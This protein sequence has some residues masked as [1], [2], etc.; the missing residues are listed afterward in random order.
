MRRTNGGLDREHGDFDCA[1][2]S[3]S[4]HRRK[5]KK[6]MLAHQ[7]N[8][9]RQYSGAPLRQ[10]QRRGDF[11]EPSS[12]DYDARSQEVEG[13]ANTLPAAG[14]TSICCLVAIG[15]PSPKS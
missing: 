6:V 13:R 15:I 14:P 9:D 7:C 1:G 3:L 4:E 2:G 8:V 12:K 10:V 5:E 11:S